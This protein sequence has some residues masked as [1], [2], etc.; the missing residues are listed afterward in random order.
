M[1][2]VMDAVMDGVMEV[3]ISA[4]ASPYFIGIGAQ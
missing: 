1:D 3:L 2:A 4:A